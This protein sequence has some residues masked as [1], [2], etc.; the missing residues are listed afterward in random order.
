M[1]IYNIGPLRDLKDILNL[2]LGVYGRKKLKSGETFTG[3]A[4]GLKAVNGDVVYDTGCEVGN[5]D[6]PSE[7]DVVLEGDTDLAPFEKISIKEG[8]AWVYL[9]SNDEGII[10]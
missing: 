8:D 5:G 9:N 10:E 3:D 7:D 2:S 6:S 4:F 1:S